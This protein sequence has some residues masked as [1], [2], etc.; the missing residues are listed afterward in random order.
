MMADA[1]ARGSKAGER[2]F[3]R[4]AQG[5]LLC[6]CTK[7]GCARGSKG[8]GAELLSLAR[9]ALRLTGR[10]K[11]VARALCGWRARL[12]ARRDGVRSLVRKALDSGGRA[13]GVCGQEKSADGWRRWGMMERVFA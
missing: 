3:Y 6:A 1:C 10:A 5:Y 11:R 8:D 2:G 7:N 9:E 13:C 4:V 12:C